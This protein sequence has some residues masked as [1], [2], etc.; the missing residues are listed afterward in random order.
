[1]FQARRRQYLLIPNPFQNCP[2]DWSQFRKT[3]KVEIKHRK[4]ETNLLA[5][6]ISVGRKITEY[7]DKT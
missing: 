3:E 4:V 5:Y 2:V 7:T 6:E 1:M